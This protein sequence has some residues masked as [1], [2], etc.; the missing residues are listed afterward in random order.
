M[1]RILFILF[2]SLA[3]VASLR[4]EHIKGGEMTY[5][6]LGDGAGPNTSRY[7]ITLK[8]YIDCNANRTGQ[9]DD[10]VP[11]TFF[12]K[13][14]S[15][16]QYG[17]AIIAPMVGEEFIRFDPASNPCI[18]NPPTDV[19]YRV[20]RYSTTVTLPNT[21]DGYVVAY[22]RCCRIRNIINLL[23]PSDTYGATYQCEIPGTAVLAD[24]YK[25]TSPVFVTNDAAAICISSNFTFSF[26][27]SQ[28]DAGDS[29]AYRL[30]SGFVGGSQAAPNPPIASRPPY[31]E[32]SYVPPFS[33]SAP[34]G[35][36]ATINPTTGLI[37]GTAPGI[38]GQYVISACAYEYRNGVLIN[39]HRKDIHVAVSNCIPLKAQLKPDY[40]YCDDFLVTFKN[41][42]LNPSGAQYIWQYGDNSKADTTTDP[43]GRVSHQY[44]DTGTY[45]VK[46][47]VVLAGQCIDS[48][49]T[50]AKVYPGF[51]P[52]FVS[53]GTCVLL[54]LQF[55]DT[56]K[57]RYGV[58]SKWRWNFG[59][60]TTQADTSRLRNPSWKYATTGFKTVELIVE[61]DKG[62]IDTVTKQVEVRDKPPITLPFKDTL[63]C[64]IDTLQ[65]NALGN[66]IFSWAPNYNIIN[67]NT[68]NPLVYPKQT[69]FYKVTL[70]ENGCI[71]TDSIRVRVVDFVTLFAGPDT[72]TCATDTIQLRP[73]SDGLQYLWTPNSTIIDPTKKNALVYPVNTTTYRVRA[74]IGKC[75]AED[76]ITVRTVPY[77]IA[78]AGPDTTI[79]YDDT[80]QLN[81]SMNG[82]RFT[83]SPTNTLN[84]GNTLTPLAFP[85]RTTT[86]TLSAYDT[87]GCPKPGISQVIVTVRDKIIPFAGNDTSIVVGQ[88]LQ[89]RGSG[90]MLYEWTP[91][92]FLS[93][94]SIQNPIANLND[95]FTYVMRAYTPEGCFALDTI[96][97]KV[98][99]TAPDI[100]VPNAFAPNGKNRI[101]RPIPVG[102]S[103]MEY[104]RVFNRWGQL[105][106]Q[107]SRAG[108][109]WDGTI[110]GKPQDAGTYVW[111]VKGTD[112]TGKVVIRRGTAVL[113][114]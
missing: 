12:D 57:S 78:D 92:N 85:L 106:Y 76:D 90:G 103:S 15:N 48:T 41:E 71:N 34:L 16:I 91:P 60:E 64:S 9:L 13:S 75:F 96:N 14:N 24:A 69:T 59:D 62:C 43:E 83:W 54:P 82:I 86:Y 102:I 28:A 79:C 114:R 65:L 22:Q 30:C 52:G 110:A 72:T 68:Q 38:L 19:C 112:F 46:L 7:R 35:G 108:D 32:L 100:F 39:I 88:P 40:S 98:F 1:K 66:G 73:Q 111:M 99:K 25:N 11:L 21:A 80:A 37:T 2:L 97:I 29:V 6:Y 81:G 18:G 63:I 5:E 77:P 58:P 45:T 89:L 93:N 42:Q 109:G 107:T 87:L 20:R 8:L 4:A 49:T 95:N 70:N 44:A 27:A 74:I 84:S 61:S 31:S 23:A 56:T 33:G 101:L 26:A 36:S 55:T 94:P 17:P 47:K 67:A 105:V 10:N 104:F 53:Q 3:T 50:L 51:Y 113:I